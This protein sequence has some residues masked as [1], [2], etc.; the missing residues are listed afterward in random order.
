M[1]CDSSELFLVYFKHYKK[2]LKDVFGIEKSYVLS[3]FRV[4]EITCLRCIPPPSHR[5]VTTV[6]VKE[7]GRLRTQ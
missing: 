6:L 1:K 3:Y 4:K 5:A 2:I 7:L